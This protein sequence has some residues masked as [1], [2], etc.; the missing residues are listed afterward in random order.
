M[1]LKRYPVRPSAR[2][3]TAKPLTIWSARRWIE[4]KAWMSARSPPKSIAMRRP[5]TQLPLQTEPQIPKKAPVSIIP[6]SPMFTT[7]ARSEKIPPMAAKASGVA[8]RRVEARTPAVRML[9]SVDASL[10]CSQAAPSVP[11]M[12][13]P[14]AHQPSFRSPRGMTATPHATARTPA[15]KGAPMPRTVHGGRASQNARMPQA[16]PSFAI[17]RGSVNLRTFSV[18][19]PH[20]CE[21]MARAPA[22]HAGRARRI[23]G[24]ASEFE[25]ED[26]DRAREPR[27]RARDRQCEEVVLGDRDAAVARGLRIEPHSPHLEAQR[28]PVEEDV[29]NDQG[30]E[31]DEQARMERRQGPPDRPQ[32]NGVRDLSGARN[33]RLRALKGAADLEE[34]HPPEDGDPVEHDRRDHLVGAD[35]RLE[36]ARYAPPDRPRDDGGED[37]DEQ[38]HRTGQ[39]LDVGAH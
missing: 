16:I 13:R 5:T 37:G 26:I 23:A 19:N 24:R 28:R 30:E 11:A 38:M 39:T 10:P 33:G 3:L 17:V 22:G 20:A 25:P 34:V 2:K 7:P 9:S 27:E 35:R 4:K 6:S 21:L 12:P 1:A 8:K 18:A 36:D 14:I 32:L 15:A 31:G 29:V